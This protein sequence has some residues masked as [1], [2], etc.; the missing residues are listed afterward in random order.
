MTPADEIAAQYVRIAH[1]LD[2]MNAAALRPIVTDAAWMTATVAR[3]AAYSAIDSEIDLVSIVR[4]G[5][6][7]EVR[8]HYSID[9]VPRGQSPGKT[10]VSHTSTDVIDVWVRNG[11]TWQLAH[12]QPVE[13]THIVN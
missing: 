2:D 9:G 8:A 6:R 10:E 13:E 5:D 12:E 11:S 3:F 7:A 4:R 1:A